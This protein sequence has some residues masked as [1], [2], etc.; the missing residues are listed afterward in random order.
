MAHSVVISKLSLLDILCD[1]IVGFFRGDFHF[2]LRHLGDFDDGIV[3]AI[4]R[5]L[6]RN[7]VPGGDGRIALAERKA[8]TFR[9]SLAGG[10]R[11]V[12]VEDGRGNRADGADGREGS[13]GGGGP[14]RGRGGGEGQ[15]GDGGEEFHSGFR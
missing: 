3:C 5:S 14:C 8:E 2:G 13:G 12:A 10:G 15:E 9:R 7:I 4:G 1:G 11:G 6:E